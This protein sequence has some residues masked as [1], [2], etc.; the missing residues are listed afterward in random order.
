MSSVEA[1]TGSSVTI[2]GQGAVWLYGSHARGDVDASSDVDLIHISEEC[3][4]DRALEA[5]C[6]RLGRMSVS[7]YS[8]REIEGM[9]SYG[10]LF[11]HHLRLE[12]KALAEST[13]CKGRLLCVLERLGPYTLASRDLGGFRRVLDDVT[14][15][16]REGYA[17]LRYELSTLGTVLRHASILSCAL[18]GDYCFSRTGPVE[19]MVS[20]HDFPKHW[21][22]EFQVLYD[23]RLFSDGR[24]EVPG[25]PN[26]QFARMW[27]SRTRLL[28]DA[29][30]QQV[31]E[32]D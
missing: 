18:R 6:A 9:A 26:V 30:E 31:H 17:S 24:R 3:E 5:V 20:F 14:N 22:Y 1:F 21:T 32:Q 16:L 19:R 12:G 27:C 4:T 25:I 15:S 28:L 8:W 13:I 29:L 11:L 23:Y 7:Q 10:S 2:D